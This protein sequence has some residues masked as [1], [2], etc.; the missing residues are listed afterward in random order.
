MTSTLRKLVKMTT[1]HIYSYFLIVW[2]CMVN[3][4]VAFNL[5]FLFFFFCLFCFVLLTNDRNSIKTPLPIEHISI[6]SFTKH[7]KSLRSAVSPGRW[8]AYSETAL[9]SINAAAVLC[10][11]CVSNSSLIAVKQQDTKLLSQ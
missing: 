9:F 11:V 1:C 5:S 4:T 6:H 7:L 3:I 2:T 8:G 10:L